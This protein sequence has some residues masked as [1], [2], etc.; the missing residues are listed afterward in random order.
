MTPVEKK[1]I[2]LGR[3]PV[4]ICIKKYTSSDLRSTDRAGTSNQ[5]LWVISVSPPAQLHEPL[6]LLAISLSATW[7]APT[8]VAKTF[9]SLLIIRLYFPPLGK[10]CFV[11]I[12][13]HCHLLTSPSSSGQN[14]CKHRNT[15]T[16]IAMY[17]DS[18]LSQKRRHWISRIK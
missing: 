9:I 17:D 8:A 6:I 3:F 15:H 11:N 4:I 13:S 12:S 5:S 10:W 16:C 1:L 14:T 18:I 2:W 7:P